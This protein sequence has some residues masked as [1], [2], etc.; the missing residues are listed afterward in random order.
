MGDSLKRKDKLEQLRLEMY[1]HY[2]ETKDEQEVVAIS[3]EL[4]KLIYE[5]I[6]LP[7][8]KVL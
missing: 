3:Q 2:K 5:F 4:D 1:M 6:S 7:R 8:E